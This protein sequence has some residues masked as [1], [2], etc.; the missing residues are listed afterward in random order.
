MK[1]IITAI[2]LAAV[3]SQAQQLWTIQMG[4]HYIGTF[5]S[6]QAC[7]AALQQWQ[8]Q[9]GWGFCTIMSN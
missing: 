2:A 5:A 4:Q 1:K 7:N 6:G 3:V 9:G 8:A